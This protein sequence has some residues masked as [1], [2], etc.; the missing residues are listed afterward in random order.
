MPR[1][2]NQL[3]PVVYRVPQYDY[4]NFMYFSKNFMHIL[5]HA[6]SGN[7]NSNNTKT[8]PALSGNGIDY[9]RNGIRYRASLSLV[10]TPPSPSPAPSVGCFLS[11]RVPLC[12]LTLEFEMQNKNE[13]I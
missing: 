3:I 8:I 1:P 2:Y 13:I 7:N 11:P 10:A 5:G 9:R 6:R 12:R 4:N